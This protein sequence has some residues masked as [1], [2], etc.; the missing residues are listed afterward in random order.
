MTMAA[1]VSSWQIRLASTGMGWLSITH[2]VPTSKPPEVRSGVAMQNR[3]PASP[4]TCGVAVER[5]SMDRRSVDQMSVF[6][7]DGSVNP[8]EDNT[9]APPVAVDEADDRDWDIEQIRGQRGDAVV[10]GFGRGI[11]NLVAHHRPKAQLCV[12]DGHRGRGYENVEMV[13]L[14]GLD[15]MKHGARPGA[16]PPK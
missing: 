5:S 13:T 4:T 3:R 7:P 16:P 9:A 15:H 2:S 14:G 11:E 6:V 10:S 1:K 8:I 12:V